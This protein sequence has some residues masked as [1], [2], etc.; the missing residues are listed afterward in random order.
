MPYEEYKHLLYLAYSWLRGVEKASE[1]KPQGAPGMRTWSLRGPAFDIPCRKCEQAGIDCEAKSIDSPVHEPGGRKEIRGLRCKLCIASKDLYCNA[2]M[3]CWIGT[4]PVRGR[5]RVIVPQ[6]EEA[7]VIDVVNGLGKRKRPE[8]DSESEDNETQ[9]EQSVAENDDEPVQRLRSG[10]VD[11][12]RQLQSRIT[13]L[14][15]ETDLLKQENAHLVQSVNS[16][17]AR[18]SVLQNRVELA[19]QQAGERDVMSRQNKD[20]NTQHKK[21]RQRQQGDGVLN[22]ETWKRCRGN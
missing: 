18:N 9:S 10:F 16:L 12:V 17:R 13:A 3:R 19:V 6:N 2:W 20:D 5:P 11:F 15:Q 4:R 7:E 14:E 22:A 8:Y 1:S 21:K